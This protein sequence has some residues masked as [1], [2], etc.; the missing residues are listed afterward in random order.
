[1]KTLR[2]LAFLALIGAA[3]AFAGPPA[4]N[5]PA[6]SAPTRNA[7]ITFTHA[8]LG[9]RLKAKFKTVDEDGD[10]DAKTF[11]LSKIPHV[12]EGGKETLSW[13]ASVMLYNRA[14]RSPLVRILFPCQTMPAEANAARLEAILAMNGAIK[15]SSAYFLIGG[16]G[17]NRMLYLVS[18]VSSEGLTAGGLETE[19]KELFRAGERSMGLWSTDLSKPL[20]KKEEPKAERD[21]KSELAGAWVCTDGVFDGVWSMTFADDGSAAVGVYVG[22]V[23][24]ENLVVRSGKFLVH[25]DSVKG[26][27]LDVTSKDGKMHTFRIELNGDTLSCTSYDNGTVTKEL[28][29]KK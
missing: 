26:D 5:A 22:G 9:E 27:F 15:D 20:A 4:G 7:P 14:G 24:P 8:D 12:T 25:S 21:W 2:R 18:E 19:L 17:K 6:A 1:M 16:N 10:G 28:K 13:S 11:L 29:R 23:K 3:P